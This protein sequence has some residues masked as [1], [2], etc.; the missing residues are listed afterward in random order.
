NIELQ[1]IRDKVL[2]RAKWV[3]KQQSFFEQFLPRTPKREY[4]IGESHFYLGKKYVL[5]IRSAEKNEVK[6]KGGELV[7]LSTDKGDK[8]LTKRLVNEWYYK[9]AKKR[10]DKCVQESVLKFNKYNIT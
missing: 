1:D 9:H 2:N 6:L 5:K 3:K 4:V 10:F 8:F 7:V